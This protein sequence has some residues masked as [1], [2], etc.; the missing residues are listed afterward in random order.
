MPAGKTG[1]PRAVRPGDGEPSAASSADAE[2][3]RL[4]EPFSPNSGTTLLAS[5]DRRNEFREHDIHKP[6][7]RHPVSISPSSAEV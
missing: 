3:Y 7:G 6:E 2:L 5:P 4:L 1:E